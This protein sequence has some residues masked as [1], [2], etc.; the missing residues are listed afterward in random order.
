MLIFAGFAKATASNEVSSRLHAM[1]GECFMPRRSTAV[2]SPNEQRHR[3]YAQQVAWTPRG[4]P[5]TTFS[6][7]GMPIIR[8]RQRD[9]VL[10]SVQLEKPVRAVFCR[11]PVRIIYGCT[12]AA[13]LRYYKCQLTDACA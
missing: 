12:A 9:V 11:V 5:L 13:F 2:P 3:I 1:H 4:F 8:Q 10:E 6:G 7:R